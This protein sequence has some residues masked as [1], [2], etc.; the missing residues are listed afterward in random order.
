MNIF[1]FVQLGQGFANLIL[2]I[3]APNK[4]CQYEEVLFNVFSSKIHII[5]VQKFSLKKVDPL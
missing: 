5:N 3:R 2:R 1:D 4:I